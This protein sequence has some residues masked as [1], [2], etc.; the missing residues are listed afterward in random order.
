M[1]GR[2]IKIRTAAQA[3][4]VSRGLQRAEIIASW[5]LAVIIISATIVAFAQSYRGL[6]LLASNY[7]H[8]DAPWKAA[9]PIMVD[10]FLAAGELR[11]FLCAVKGDTRWNVRGWAWVLTIAG[12]VVSVGGNILHDGIHATS[13]EMAGNAVPPLA[14]AA[15]LGLG[16]G[17]VKDAVTRAKA[18]EELR[19]QPKPKRPA[20]VAERTEEPHKRNVVDIHAKR[21]P[22]PKLDTDPA[23]RLLVQEISK[24]ISKGASF[25][26]RGLREAYGLSSRHIARQVLA[27][28]RGMA[29]EVASG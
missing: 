6:L 20:V 8:I 22:K 18:A 7:L 15:A 4:T 10:V 17:L 24:E 26:E 9:W 21:G 2:M 3:V 12:L 25:T 11:L 29:Q 14:A 13:I 19:R 28:A 27:A 23:M 16:L 5:A 1:A